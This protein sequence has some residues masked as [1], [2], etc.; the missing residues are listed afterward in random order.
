MCYDL[1]IDT[2]F[3][4]WLIVC[5]NVLSYGCE[6]IYLTERNIMD[7]DKLQARLIKRIVG[8]GATYRTTALLQALKVQ[9]KCNIIDFNNVLLFRNIMNNNSA[10]KIFNM[11]LLSN[12]IK[13][14]FKREVVL[15][16]HIKQQNRVKSFIFEHQHIVVSYDVVSLFTNIP[17]K[18]TIDIVTDYV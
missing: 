1:S 7:L 15:N 10:A 6:I 12:K 11:N 9:K 3:H 16:S 14:K 4:I 17:L 2:S 5:Q 8:I 13:C 18:E